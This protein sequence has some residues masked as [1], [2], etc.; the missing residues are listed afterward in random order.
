VADHADLAADLAAAM[1]D[2]RDRLR[3]A[4]EAR[5]A[6]YDVIRR[7]AAAGMTVRAIARASGLSHQRIGQ[8][9]NRRGN[10]AR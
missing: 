2:Y 3:A 4:D 8:I 10:R 7:A 6:L 1:S 9:T 5:E